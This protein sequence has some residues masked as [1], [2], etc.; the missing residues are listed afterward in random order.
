MRWGGK[1]IRVTAQLTD[2]EAGSDIWG[3]RYDRDL[4]D[5]LGVPGQISKVVVD[6][7]GPAISEA[8]RKRAMARPPES[9]GA[10]EAYQRALWHWSRQGAGSLANVRRFLKKAV[11][12]DERLAEAHATFAYVHLS[13][14]TRGLHRQPH[15]SLKMAE[16]EARAAIAL[17]LTILVGTPPWRGHSLIRVSGTRPGRGQPCRKAWSK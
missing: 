13:D 10:W 5:I 17:D 11:A 3:D 9:L 6:A 16:D 7:L 12:L 1:R 2:A 4:S 15:Q 14:F 8:E